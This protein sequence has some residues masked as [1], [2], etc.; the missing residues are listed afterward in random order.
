MLRILCL[1][2]KESESVGEQTGMLDKREN[3]ACPSTRI[4]IGMPIVEERLRI[5]NFVLVDGLDFGQGLLWIF[6]P[7]HI[8]DRG[9]TL[10]FVRVKEIPGGPHRES[11]ANDVVEENIVED[12]FSPAENPGLPADHVFEEEPETG[13]CGPCVLGNSGRLGQSV[14]STNRALII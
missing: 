2:V 10:Q 12:V 8:I 6:V 9:P 1:R 11:A 3:I 5:D 14:E 13:I 4:V 7:H